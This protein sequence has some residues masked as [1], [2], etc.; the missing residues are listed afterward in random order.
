MK[1]LALALV[2]IFAGCVPAEAVRQARHEAAINEGH[3]SDET[4]PVE[5]RMIGA[6]N[7][8]AWAAQ[9]G[10]LTGDIDAQDEAE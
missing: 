6:A 1:H 10:S 7:A 5:A 8:A 2:V 3:A 9:L 4:L